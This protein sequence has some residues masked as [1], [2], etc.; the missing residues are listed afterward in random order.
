MKTLI[1]MDSSGDSRVEFDDT[2]ATEAARNEA[3][4]LFER[5]QGQGGAAFVL[6]R[7]K[8]DTKIT[9][10]SQVEGETVL[11]PRVVGG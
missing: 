1:V 3:R 9:D 7:E 10:F 4:A 2:P 11:V 5:V 6:D 8:G